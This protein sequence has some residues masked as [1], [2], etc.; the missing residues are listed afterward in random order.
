M[1]V[2]RL[3]G[4][5]TV[6]DRFA[7]R[8]N[9]LNFLRLFFAV[10]VIVTHAWQTAGYGFGP[11][12]AGKPVGYWAVMGFFAISGY[13]VTKSRRKYD[14]KTFM[15]HRVLRI[16]P[17][18]LVCLLMIAAVFAPLSTAWGSGNED[19]RSAAEFVGRNLLLK[20]YQSG[21]D[22]TLLHTPSHSPAWNVSLWTLFYEFACYIAVGLLL[23]AATRYHR[24]LVLAAFVATAA[25]ASANRV[26]YAGLAGSSIERFVWLAPFFFAGSLMALYA[27]RIPLN[28]YI[29]LAVLVLVPIGA[30]LNLAPAISALPAAYLVVL[31][32]VALPLHRVGAVN[33]ISYG[34][35]IYAFPVQ[36]LMNEIG[37]N[38]LPIGVSL[39]IAVLATVP[40]A[41]ASWFFV[42]RPVLYWY[43]NR[44]RAIARAPK[45][46]IAT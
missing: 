39:T 5:P 17:A 42:E 14:L 15:T 25:V 2:R 33:D 26:P 7:P 22:A 24:L 18:Y 31:L 36:Q 38:R 40:V 3:A 32:G 43:R 19:V 11:G 37:A 23:C 27:K 44:T 21:I 16:Y 34:M 12:I 29:G 9:S 28:G 8:K 30:Q 4:L 6:S 45:A 41:A 10:T 1:V 46:V 20:E 35:Y 13:F